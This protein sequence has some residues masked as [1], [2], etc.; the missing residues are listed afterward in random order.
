MQNNDNKTVLLF[1]F[2]KML[3][4]MTFGYKNAM[5]NLGPL[6]IISTKNRKFSKAYQADT[7]P[8]K[9][10]STYFAGKKDVYFALVT[11]SSC[12]PSL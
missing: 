1:Y 6:G 4:N 11:V 12:L 9:L 2:E 10:Y 3:F 7:H 8:V 5:H